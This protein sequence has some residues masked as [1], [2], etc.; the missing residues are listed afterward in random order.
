MIYFNDIEYI[1]YKTFYKLIQIL[2]LKENLNFK[3][4]YTNNMKWW[5]MNLTI[6]LIII[7]KILM[8]H[9]KMK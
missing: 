8:I 4:I 9:L 6:I 5:R 7:N 2:I 1:K 3:I